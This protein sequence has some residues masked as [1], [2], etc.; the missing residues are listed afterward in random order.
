MPQRLSRERGHKTSPFLSILLGRT[1]VFWCK[2]LDAQILQTSEFR[3][4]AQHWVLLKAD[5]PRFSAQ[6][7]SIQRHNAALLKIYGVEGFPML[8]FTDGKG[9]ERGRMGYSNASASLFVSQLKSLAGN[10]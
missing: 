10:P 7:D 5:F 3:Q 8:I 9:N 6:P 1:G 4:A 2:R